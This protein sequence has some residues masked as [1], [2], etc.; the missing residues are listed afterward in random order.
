[1]RRCRAGMGGVGARVGGVGARVGGVGPHIIRDVSAESVY[2]RVG[3]TP[4]D[5]HWPE[6]YRVMS[7]ELGLALGGWVTEHIGST[8]VP[9]L[10]AKPVIDIVVMVPEG[11]RAI[12]RGDRL[13]ASGWTVP[14]TIG[15]H[16]CSFRLR[17]N[18]RTAIAH[19]FAHSSW[20]TAHQRLFASWLRE[21]PQDRDGYSELKQRLVDDGVWGAEYTRAKTSFVQ[22]VVDQA[23]AARGLQPGPVW[24]AD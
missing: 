24:D 19:F 6:M 9:G 12:D 4:Y 18:V 3:I 8:S 11:C 17:G 1:M 15:S 23:R 16:D 20:P 10:A 5:S 14:G 21:H 13:T 22:R 7:T 2:P